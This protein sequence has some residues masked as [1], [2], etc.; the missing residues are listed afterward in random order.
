MLLIDKAI[1][2]FFTPTS[3]KEPEKINWRI[4]NST[5]LIGKYTPKTVDKSA[6]PASKRRKVAAFDLVSPSTDPECHVKAE[7]FLT[8]ICGAVGFNTHTNNIR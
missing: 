1:A 8:H 6:E 4:L 2:T 7:F 5:L 3:K